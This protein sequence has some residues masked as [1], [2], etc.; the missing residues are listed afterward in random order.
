M[1]KISVIIPIYN[2]APYLEKCIESILKQSYKDW[3]IIA[4]DDGSTDGSGDICDKYSSLDNRIKTI[5]QKN[6][7]P[8]IARNTGMAKAKGEYIVFVDA[9]DYIDIDY[10][11]Y[12][13]LH[14]EDIVFIDIN[15]VALNGKVIRTESLS[16]YSQ[17]DKDSIL[18]KQMTG[19]IPWGGWRK[20]IK[21]DI[22]VHNNIKYTK[23]KI[24]EEAIYSF[25]IMYYSKTMGFIN[26][27]VYFYLQREDSQSHTIMEDP[28][29]DVAVNLRL[30]I[31][32]LDEYERYARTLN[33]FILAAA[34]GSTYRIAS[35]YSYSIYKSKIKDRYQKYL[36]ESDSDYGIDT[37]SLSFRVRALGF[38]FKNKLFFVAWI[39]SRIK[40]IL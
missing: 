4:V 17:G 22:I 18:R 2:A 34:T 40:K 35:Q 39:V 19:C 29:G 16:D 6:S 8:G 25:L 23:H 10:F 21:R 24:G 37:D 20:A 30:K 31:K 13:S 12:L 15:E 14:K 1:P 9:D 38:L 33:A 36:H 3:E 26:K 32:E 28:W 11:Y 27:P 7:G 5:H